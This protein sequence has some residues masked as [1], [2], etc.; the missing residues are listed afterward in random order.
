MIR[1][2]LFLVNPIAGTR[3]KHSLSEY[4][5]KTCTDAGIEHSFV[6]S[7]REMDAEWLRHLIH[8]RR[9]TDLVA[10]GGD[11]TVNL[12]ASAVQNTPINLGIIA[13]GS[14]NGLARGAGIPLKPS[15]ALKLILNGQTMLID[16]F[17]INNH[18]SCMLSGVGFD[19]AVAERFAKAAAAD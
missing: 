7:T 12:A 8:D 4:L 17:T 18:F 13:V 5:A 16:A 14:G 9:A 6:E 11:G 19:A 3:T 2:L 10:C 15:L 1:N